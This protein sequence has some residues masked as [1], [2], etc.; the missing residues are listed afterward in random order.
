MRIRNKTDIG[1]LN[2]GGIR[3]DINAGDITYKDI[4]S[5]QPFGNSLCIIKAKGQAIL[6]ALEFSS[7]YVQKQY[8]ASD[9]S[10]IGE[11]GG[12]AQVSGLKYTIDT[13]V[14]P[15]IET[16]DT[17]Y[18]TAVTGERRVRDVMVVRDDG[19]E[20]PLDPEAEYTI[21]GATFTL[22]HGGDGQTAFADAELVADE[23]TVDYMNLADFIVEDLKGVIG[24]EYAK[25]QGRITVR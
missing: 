22:I 10:A 6:D 11:T 18:F 23:V 15:S 21:C 20:E 25:P 8:S 1:W 17:G 12:F 13:S 16:D 24:D 7:R 4:I 9:G 2:G 3:A 5:V 14:S 19:S